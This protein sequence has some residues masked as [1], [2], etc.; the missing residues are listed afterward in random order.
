MSTELDK[1]RAQLDLHLPPNA[2]FET[3]SP[4]PKSAERLRP[5]LERIL[6]MAEESENALSGLDTAKQLVDRFGS[7]GAVRAC[8]NNFQITGT[9]DALVSVDEGGRFSYRFG[10]TLGATPAGKCIAERLQAMGGTEPVRKVTRG[11]VV[12]ITFRSPPE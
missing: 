9:L 5:Q 1:A 8:T 11:G 12:F 7:S 6:R 3:G 4:D 10:G 2:R